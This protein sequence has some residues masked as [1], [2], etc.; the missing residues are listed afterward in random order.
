MRLLEEPAGPLVRLEYDIEVPEGETD[1]IPE[2][3]DRADYK[4]IR[5]PGIRPR[6]LACLLRLA[7]G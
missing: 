6:R 2:D 3:W 7:D 4:D 1:L 5:R